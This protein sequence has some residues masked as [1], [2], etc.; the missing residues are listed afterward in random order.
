MPAAGEL[1]AVGK[2]DVFERRSALDLD[3]L[4]QRLQF[5]PNAIAHL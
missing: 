3:A 1:D 2:Q 5:D 4:V